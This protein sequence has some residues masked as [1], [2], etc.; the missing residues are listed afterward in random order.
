[1]GEAQSKLEPFVF[2][3]TPRKKPFIKYN[4]FISKQD[5]I[6]KTIR[7]AKTSIA[8]YKSL[9]EIIGDM[10]IAA[11]LKNGMIYFACE[12]QYTE[13]LKPFLTDKVREVNFNRA[14]INRDNSVEISLLYELIFISLTNVVSLQ[15][16]GKRRIIN[17]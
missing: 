14:L 2:A 7:C 3:S 12:L 13:H 15:R 8:N 10:P 1:M 9:K 6:P 5:G 17:T 16:V 4:A 11:A